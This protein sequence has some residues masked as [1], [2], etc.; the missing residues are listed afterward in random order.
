[1]ARLF[2]DAS[3]E[4]LEIDSAVVTAEPF[5]LAAWIYSDSSSVA[6]GVLFIGDKDNADAYHS[7]RLR[8]AA[9]GD[10]IGA[11][12]YDGDTAWAS[13]SSGY[14]TDTWHHACGVWSATNSRAAYIDGGSKGTNSTSQSL[15][16]TPDRTCI[17]RSGDSTPGHYMS[18]Y[19]ADAA[20]WNAALSDAEVAVL[21]AGFS[22]LFVKPGNLVAYWP[23]IRDEDQ[24]IVGGYDMTAYNTPTIAAHPPKLM[25]PAPPFVITAPPVVAVAAIKGYMTPMRGWWGP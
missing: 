11:L 13:T 3:T 6:Q 16:Q 5:T 12:T 8:G 10:P 20:I 22:P 7:L 9:E 25:R 4:Y 1:M 15:P 21:A 2:D 23:L 17:G 24:D 19:I 18:G 14:S